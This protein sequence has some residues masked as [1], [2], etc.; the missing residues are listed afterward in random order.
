MK[1]N[2]V[3]YFAIA[4]S[5]FVAG[6]TM[7]TV[8]G[9][10]NIVT[11]TPTVS[12]FEEIE[13]AS[14]CDVTIYHGNEFKVEVSDYENLLQYLKFEVT[15]KKLTIKT[16]PDNISLNNSKAKATIYMP[17]LLRKLTISGSSD[18]VL[19]DGFKDITD[20]NVS[21]SG[22]ITGTQPAT[23]NNIRATIEGSGDITM[24]G[25]ANNL[26]LSIEGS[27]N[28]DFAGVTAQAATCSI[29]GS[30]DI[31]VNAA[32]ALSATINGSGDILYYGNPTVTQKIN[33][34]GRV[35]KR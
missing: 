9:S 13:V 1:N 31:I 18:I 16:E 25:T 23:M 2:S 11:Q 35:K 12:R 15:G 10:G 28:I 20:L 32:V 30:G 27:G 24:T 6:C 4:L 3:L 14:H 29:D 7:N 17:D 19:N 21:G 8:T 26:D 22:N 5:I 34:S 33:G